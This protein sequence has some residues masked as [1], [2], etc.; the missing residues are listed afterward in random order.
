MVKYVEAFEQN[1]IQSSNRSS[2][3]HVYG[4]KKTLQICNYYYKGCGEK[5]VCYRAA[6]SR[7]QGRERD[8]K[9]REGQEKEKGKP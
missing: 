4:E 5:G 7:V 1:G 8:K 6:V 9:E 2:C 3:A